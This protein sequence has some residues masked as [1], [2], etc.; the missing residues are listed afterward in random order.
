MAWRGI[1]DRST[2]TFFWGGGGG[3]KGARREA[4]VDPSN[5]TLYVRGLPPG[6]PLEQLKQGLSHY[7]E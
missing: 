4:P 2:G 7:G 3:G 5:T 6:Y 1:I